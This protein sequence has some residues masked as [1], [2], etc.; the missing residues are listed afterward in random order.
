MGV[1][2]LTTQPMLSEQEWGLIMQLLEHEHQDLPVERRHTDSRSY[3]DALDERKMM[4]D[5][6]IQRLRNQGVAQ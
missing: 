2:M 4:I 1:T 5:D 3:A 6:L